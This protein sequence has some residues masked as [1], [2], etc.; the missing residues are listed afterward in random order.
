EV[1]KHGHPARLL[2][3]LTTP[4][5]EWIDGLAN[6][7]H[8]EEKLAMSRVLAREGPFDRA[9]SRGNLRLRIWRFRLQN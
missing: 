8:D 4:L 5:P 9:V 3:T 1:S 7:C 2:G 6:H